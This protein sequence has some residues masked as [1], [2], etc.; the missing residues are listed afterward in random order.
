MKRRGNIV[1]WLRGSQKE[2]F[3]PSYHKSESY[4]ELARSLAARHN[5]FFAYDAGGYKGDDVFEPVSD[6]TGDTIVPTTKR[7]V[8][9]VIYNLGNIP[10]ED[11]KT[12]RAGIT[13]TPVFKRFCFSKWDTYQYLSEFSPQTIPVLTEAEFASAAERI[14]TDTVVFK[15][16][17]GMNGV[18]VRIFEKTTIL[19]LDAAPNLRLDE[20]MKIEINKGAILQEFVDTKNGIPGIC[21]S[22][23]DLRIVTINGKIVLTHVRIPE[24]GSRIANYQ[25]GATIRELALEMLPKEIISFYTKVHKKIIAR[26]PKPM[27]SMDI[28][29]GPDGPILFE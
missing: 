10:G 14:K 8:A 15:P 3:A 25:Q 12:F 20:E 27:Y 23:H 22:Y 24:S 7:V 9:D 21:D 5:L 2:T 4:H 6:Y 19:P 17:K 11:F 28:G 13:N 29:M 26:F 1:I 18:A 16:N